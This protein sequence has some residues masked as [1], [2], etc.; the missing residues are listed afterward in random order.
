VRQHA[1]KEI[2]I[3]LDNLST[4]TTPDVLAWL[5]KN[6]NITFHFTG[7]SILSGHYSFPAGSRRAR[8]VQCNRTRRR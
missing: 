8:R 3:V 1:G 5:E 6:P 7:S 4:H 2:R